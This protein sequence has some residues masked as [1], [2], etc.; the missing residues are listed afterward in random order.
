MD[1]PTD[2]PTDKASYTISCRDASKKERNKAQI[3]K[4]HAG[5]TAG[6]QEQCWRRSLGHLGRS[7]MLKKLENTEKVKREMTDRPTDQPTDRHSGV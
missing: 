6:G 7:S 5:Y 1:R 2:G 3:P 4:L